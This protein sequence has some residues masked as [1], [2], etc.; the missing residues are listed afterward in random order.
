M[1]F[2]DPS[3]IFMNQAACLYLIT[4]CLAKT[5]IICMYLYSREIVDLVDVFSYH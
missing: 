1:V 4:D 2:F 3:K 5:G